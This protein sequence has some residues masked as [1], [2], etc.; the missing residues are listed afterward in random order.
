MK[1]RQA[2]WES[3]SWARTFLNRGCL[4]GSLVQLHRRSFPRPLEIITLLRVLLGG[5]LET[6]WVTPAMRVTKYEG[7]LTEQMLDRRTRSCFQVCTLKHPVKIVWL[8]LWLMS[9]YEELVTQFALSV[10]GMTPISIV[11]ISWGRR[12]KNLGSH[13]YAFVSTFF[14]CPLSLS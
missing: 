3:S 12:F 11:N 5:G 10:E 14:G 8:I 13:I 4:R 2:S 7:T 9:D 1:A 6:R